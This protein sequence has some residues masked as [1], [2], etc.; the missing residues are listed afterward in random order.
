M[1]TD[2]ST[3]RVALATKEN[4][5]SQRGVLYGVSS[6][7]STVTSILLTN[8]PMDRK[9][10]L[11]LQVIEVILPWENRVA[12]LVRVRKFGETHRLGRR[13]REGG[14]FHTHSRFTHS[15]GVQVG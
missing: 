8:L 9:M 2:L 5:Q 15:Q 3:F 4:L 1:N 7:L 13:T 10:Y 12:N 11:R 14:N 6:R